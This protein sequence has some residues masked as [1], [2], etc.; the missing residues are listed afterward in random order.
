MTQLVIFIITSATQVLIY[1]CQD[2]QSIC[3]THIVSCPGAWCYCRYFTT[4]HIDSRHT[5]TTLLLLL[6]AV[7]IDS[8]TLLLHQLFNLVYIAFI[9]V[10]LATI[11]KRFAIQTLR[12]LKRLTSTLPLIVVV[13][14]VVS[15]LLYL[16]CFRGKEVNGA[17][18][19]SI[20]LFLVAACT[21][22]ILSLPKTLPTVLNIHFPLYKKTY[23]ELLSSWTSHKTIFFSQGVTN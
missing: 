6:L 20:G 14:I 21:Q 19:K 23:S 8:R 16:I 17:V 13:T 10:Y 18:V 7:H 1:V 15:K 12:T 11:C 4:V 3:D 2:A 22:L 9:A 5:I